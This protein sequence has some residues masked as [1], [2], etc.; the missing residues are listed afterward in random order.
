MNLN[1]IIDLSG[2]SA[3]RV[4]QLFIFTVTILLGACATTVIQGR[5]FSDSERRFFDDGIDVV[6]DVD[7]LQGQYGFEERE[8]L[9]ARC[10]LADVIAEVTIVAVH[11]NEDAAGVAVKRLEVTINRLFYGEMRSGEFLLSSNA[12]ALGYTLLTR[13]EAAL[14]GRKIMFLR[15]FFPGEGNDS[16]GHHFHL[17]PAS[18]AMKKSVKHFVDKRIGAESKSRGKKQSSDR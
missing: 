9:D 3:D 6:E 5:S 12:N 4:R 16:S 10:N 2:L 18:D 13:H 11:D 1:F 17:T 8:A 7:S 14:G 15:T